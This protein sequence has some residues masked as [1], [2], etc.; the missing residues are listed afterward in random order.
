MWF[1]KPPEAVSEVKKKNFRECIQTPSIVVIL[2][3]HA[4]NPLPPKCQYDGVVTMTIMNVTL[5]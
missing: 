2:L 5:A 3:H 4:R 1:Q